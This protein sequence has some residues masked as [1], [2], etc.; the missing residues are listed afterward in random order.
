MTSSDPTGQRFRIASGTTRAEIAQVGAALRALSVDDVDLVP[1]YADDIPTPSAS[2]IVLV[3]WPNRVRD[4]KWDANGQDYQLAIT[5]PKYQN[6]SHGLLR[7]APYES[8]AETADAVTLSARVFP[9]TGYPFFLETSV[10]YAVRENALDVTH[11]ILNVGRVDAP[12]AVGAHPYF[13]IGDVDTAVLTLRSSGATRFVVDDRMLPVGREPVDEATDLRRGRTLGDLDLDT[14]YGDLV[15]DADGRA[16][17]TLEAPDRRAVTVWQ[18]EDLDFVQVFTTDRFPGRPL[19]VA[20]EP[21]TAPADAFN[22]GEHLRW[23]APGE[24]W[25]LRWGVA[26]SG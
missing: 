8:T 14:A 11:E 6:A 23:L 9:Q 1:R 16:R 15:R 5:E 2:G 3:P 21:M 10:T 18:G 20:I 22:S 17:A 19:A 12:V 24:S 13:C 25:T 7:F 26:Y 4:G